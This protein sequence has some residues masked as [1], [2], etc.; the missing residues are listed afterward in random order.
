[1]KPNENKSMEQMDIEADNLALE[2]LMP[3]KL[4]EQNFP[5]QMQ[6]DRII[7]VMELQQI[8]NYFKV[9]VPVAYARFMQ[10]RKKLEYLPKAFYA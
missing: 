7:S 9:S 1:M 8:A 10:L 4:L 2:I 3:K 6:Q 5:F